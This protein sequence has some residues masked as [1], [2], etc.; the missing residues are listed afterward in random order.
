MK[1]PMTNKLAGGLS[2]LSQAASARKDNVSGTIILVKP[3]DCFEEDNP[4]TDFDENL[5]KSYVADF[6]DP[7]IGQKEPIQLYPANKEGKYR[8]QH[9]A[10]RLR[11]G[12]IA[13]KENPA[14]KLKAIVDN[15]LNNKDE[16]ENYFDRAMNNIKRDNMTLLD[17]ANFIGNYLD[18]AKQSGKPVTQAE[19]ANRLGFKGGASYVSR[20]LK[21][22]DMT[23]EM[24]EVYQS[25]NI[26][27]IEALAT[28]AEIQKDKPELFKSLIELPDL[29][30]ATIRKAKKTGKIKETETGTQQETAGHDTEPK[31]KTEPGAN[32][33]LSQSEVDDSVVAIPFVDYLFQTGRVNILIKTVDNGFLAALETVFEHGINAEVDF[34]DSVVW[35]TEDEAIDFGKKQIK[36]WAEVVLAEKDSLSVEEYQDIVG[37]LNTLKNVNPQNDNSEKNKDSGS[38][39]AKTGQLTAVIFVEVNG[40]EGLLLLKVPKDHIGADESNVH[41]NGFVYVQIGSEIRAV[42]EGEYVIKSVS[43]RE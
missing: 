32:T 38:R 34:K 35:D 28:L 3:S 6:L 12:L 15:S 18:K 30:R 11:A 29:D 7:E 36:D 26:D 13:E 2:K 20:L 42:K 17:R 21:L 14:F 16:L 4:R 1:T 10:T 40:E 22:R 37:Y 25:G 5:I 8:V 43:Y 31:S 33:I 41:T 27:D 24:S 19:I 23:P 39:K 9:G